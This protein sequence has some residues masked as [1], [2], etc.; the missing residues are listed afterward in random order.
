MAALSVAEG[1]PLPSMSLLPALRGCPVLALST[2]STTV[3]TITGANLGPVDA[4]NSVSATYKAG[5]NDV[6]LLMPYYDVEGRSEY[7]FSCVSHLD[8]RRKRHFTSPFLPLTPAPLLA[9]P[10]RAVSCL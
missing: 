9:I 1:S 6:S 4:K 8:P 3:V 10:R 7:S 2:T 5:D